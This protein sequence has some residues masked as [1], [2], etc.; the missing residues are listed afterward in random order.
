METS[1]CY[2]RRSFLPRGLFPR[3]FPF[4]S[5]P[6]LQLVILTA[7]FVFGPASRAFADV[8]I[9]VDAAQ[10][11]GYI[12]PLVFGQNV[13]FDCNSMWDHR[14]DTLKAD[15]DDNNVI[16]KSRIEE[17]APTILRFPGGS[18]SD[19]YIWEDGLGFKTPQEV[20]NTN[21]TTIDLGDS[22]VDW[23]GV[24]KGLIID[25]QAGSLPYEFLQ[26]QLGDDF[27]YVGFDAA[28]NRLTGVTILDVGHPPGAGVRPGGRP[29]GSQ[30][31]ISEDYWTHNYGI[32]E[33][34]NLVKS[35]GA[36]ALITV[37]YGTGLDSAGQIS[38]NASLSQRIKRAQALVAFCNGA[39]GDTRPLGTDGE[40]RNWGTVGYWAGKRLAMGYPEPFGVLYWEVGNE[41]CFTFEAGHTTANDYADKFKQFA[42]KMK[43][44]D[45]QIKVG[46][47][48][49]NLPTC[50]GDADPYNV[51]WNQTVIQQTKDYLDFLVIHS[52]YPAVSIFPD[53]TSDAW[54]KLVMAGT[55]QAGKHLAEIKG[56]IDA[57]APGRE[58]S[59]AVTE[60]G[61]GPPNEGANVYSNLARALHDADLLM[62]LI[63]KEGSD[64]K[65]GLV[66]A[67]N[68][69]LHSVTPHAAI[70]LTWI[71]GS[72]IIR[73]QY[74]ALKMLRQNLAG[75]QL[76]RTEVLSSP[77]FSIDAKEGN[78]DTNPAVP[79][80]EALGA[81]SSDGKRLTLAVINRSLDSFPNPTITATIQFNNLLFA[82]KCAM[83]TKLTSTNP[84]DHNE[85]GEIVKP[86]GPVTYA[87]VPQ[88]FNFAPHSLTII[89]FRPVQVDAVINL[90]MLFDD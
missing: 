39:T 6:F 70:G 53:Y 55:I 19:V 45:F 36:Q 18:A 35:L 22:P 65:L 71:G 88:S 50:N 16:V 12:N 56:I 72:R 44:V 43:E 1:F 85:A 31:G 86:S 32:I 15:A 66:A 41:L 57:N 10:N 27:D 67:A 60:Y 89:E 17:L 42:Q 33:H 37:N 82:P 25:P 87:P 5:T 81:L 61:F 8:T 74:Y 80:L 23:R 34:L 62:Y 26:G 40:G 3:A 30:W 38:T 77:T 76:V 48:G 83:V 28:N 46:A 79:C 63:K 9:A 47:V 78:I 29:G 21:P 59:L 68:W 13:V 64:T 51:P 20:I 73:P 84:G 90:L 69:D 49:H 52:Y 58:V 7:L 2:T 14:T 11:Q 54:F 75:R 24:M 4:I